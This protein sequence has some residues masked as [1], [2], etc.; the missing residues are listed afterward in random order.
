M[1]A[2]RYLFI[3]VISTFF[4]IPQ[5]S[6]A[7]DVTLNNARAQVYFSPKGGCTEAIVEAITK[8]GLSCH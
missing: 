3:L 7:T 2:H 8:A 4:F 6:L 1:K 5:Y